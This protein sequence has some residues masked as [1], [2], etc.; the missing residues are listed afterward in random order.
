MATHRKVAPI[1]SEAKAGLLKAVAAQFG[2]KRVDWTPAEK[3]LVYKNFL[4]EIEVDGNKRG[5]LS[6]AIAMLPPER[7]RR[8]TANAYTIIGDLE[9]FAKKHARLFKTSKVLVGKVTPDDTVGVFAARIRNCLIAGGVNNIAELLKRTEQELMSFPNMGVKSVAEV[10]E[11]LTKNGL[12]LATV[13]LTAVKLVAEPKPEPVVEPAEPVGGLSTDVPPPLARPT[14]LVVLKDYMDK[15]FA[16]LM[17]KLIKDADDRQLATV[18]LLIEQLDTK[19]E[20]IEHRIVGHI[21]DSVT[22]MLTK[23]DTLKPAKVKKPAVL[24]IGGLDAQRAQI[25]Q[26]FPWIE[27]ESTD[28]KNMSLLSG[29]GDYNLVI[30]WCTFSSHSIENMLKSKYGT[31]GFVS[32]TPGQGMSTIIDIISQRFPKP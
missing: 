23:L 2:P 30:Q 18:Q 6:R 31:H 7:Q 12:K 3:V 11:L 20:A 16:E 26:R 29:K 21:D 28:G 22:R 10:K 17:T 4:A 5:A 25:Q 13:K 9:T 27:L 24:L 8:S 14:M 15:V 19:L 1:S 32:V